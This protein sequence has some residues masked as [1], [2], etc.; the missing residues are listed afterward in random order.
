MISA[1]QL[2]V[3]IDHRQENL[4]TGVSNYVPVF[5]YYVPVVRGPNSF[6]S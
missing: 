6:F 5:I 3:K 1:P 4:M 2:I